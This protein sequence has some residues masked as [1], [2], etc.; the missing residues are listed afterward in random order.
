MHFNIFSC[1]C[2]DHDPIKFELIN[3]SIPKKYF[4]FR[5]KNTWLKEASFHSEIANFW[6]NLPA[7]HLLAKLIVV[8]TSMEKWGR[9]SFINLGTK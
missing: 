3:T 1:Y 5:F 9:S 6:Q 8:S 2:S 4:R 7:M